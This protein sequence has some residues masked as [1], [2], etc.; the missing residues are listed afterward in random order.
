MVLVGLFFNYFYA[1]CFLSFGADIVSFN[2]SKEFKTKKSAAYGIGSKTRAKYSLIK[3]SENV[4]GL[5]NEWRV[6]NSREKLY[7][8]CIVTLYSFLSRK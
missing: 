8:R 1:S 3:F 7:D 4:G 6:L 5:N 2:D